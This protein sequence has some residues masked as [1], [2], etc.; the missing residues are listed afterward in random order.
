MFGRR[1]QYRNVE[2]EPDEIFL[3]SHNSPDYN[4]HQLEGRIERS[5]PKYT[6]MLL[7]GFFILI[8]LG[9]LWRVGTLQI[10]EGEKFLA[11][12]E[13]N[14]LQHAIIFSERGVIFDRN[15]E[16]LAWNEPRTTYGEDENTY[17]QIQS[18]NIFSQRKYTKKSG[19]SHVLGFIRNPRKDAKGFYYAEEISGEEGVERAYNEVLSG[20]NGLQLIEHDAQGNIQASHVVSHSRAGD[21]LVLTIDSEIQT[22]LSQFLEEVANDRGFEGGAGVIMDIQNGE[23]LALTSVPEYSSEKLS[24]GEDALAISSY[25]NNPAKPFL[26]RGIAGLYAPGSI[27]KPFVAF[28]ALSE[29]IIFPEKEIISTGSISV[30]N[31]YF[32]DLETVFYDWKAHGPVNMTKALAVSSNIYFYAIGG[33][34]EDQRGLG[35]RKIEN[36]MR[37]FGFGEETQIDLFGEEDGLIPNPEWKSRVFGDEWRKGDTYNTAIGQYGFQVTP[38]QAAYATA[39][40]AQKGKVGVPHVVKAI[41]KNVSSV[42]ESADT[43]RENVV[44]FSK[45]SPRFSSEDVRNFEQIHLG[46]REAVVSGT[47]NGLFMGDVE[48]AAKTGTAEIGISKKYVNSWVIGF[49]PYENPRFSFAIVLERGPKDNTVGALFS[50]RKLLEWMQ[51]NTP[52][53]L[54]DI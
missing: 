29:K 16:Q 39:R 45:K 37:Q 46:M 2:I 30:P 31:P 10:F 20:E 51:V 25:Q 26:N 52:E 1:K 7:G 21:N 4:P 38:L 18:R 54:K 41:E 19:F 5:I 9:F 32:P 44:T 34:H 50:M 6:P 12:A 49:F 13:N 43:V 3:D 22:K 27:V 24:L 15:G 35:I 17:S 14:R 11:L 33:G 53:Y 47:A 42:S 28:A 36:Y 8:A 40:I 23:V 48:I